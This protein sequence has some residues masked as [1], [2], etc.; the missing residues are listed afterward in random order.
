[1]KFLGSDFLGVTETGCVCHGVVFS[2][3]DFDSNNYTLF[4][5]LKNAVLLPLVRFG[6]DFILFATML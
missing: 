6:Q 4:G 2:F 3:C 1:M 5:L